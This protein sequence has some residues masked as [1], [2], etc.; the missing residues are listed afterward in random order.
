MPVK[1]ICHISFGT[2]YSA[3]FE[4]KMCNDKYMHSVA[5]ALVSSYDLLLK[6]TSG[7][8]INFKSTKSGD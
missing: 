1:T 2:R 8:R 4:K 7:N 3:G 6:L 5:A